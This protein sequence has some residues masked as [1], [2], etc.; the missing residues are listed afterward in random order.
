MNGISSEDAEWIDTEI[1][2]RYFTTKTDKNVITVL[3]RINLQL[4]GI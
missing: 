4:K 2:K 1:K 3:F